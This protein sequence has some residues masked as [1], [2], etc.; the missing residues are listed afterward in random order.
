MENNVKKY[1]LARKFTLQ[2]LADLAGT[3][4]SYIWELEQGKYSPSIRSAYAIS[5][6]LGK[7][8]FAVFPD[9]QEYETTEIKVTNLK[10]KEA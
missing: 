10:R 3:G 8:V 6:A 4:K 9:D 5:K 7:T 1:R 2:K